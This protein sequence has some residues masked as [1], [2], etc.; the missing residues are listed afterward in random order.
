[1]LKLLSSEFGSDTNPV[2][3]FQQRIEPVAKTV[4]KEP[5][6]EPATSEPQQLPVQKE[7]VDATQVE[8]VSE[9]LDLGL[10]TKDD[11]RDS[12]EIS[13]YFNK[14]KAFIQDSNNPKQDEKYE[15]KLSS[16]N[17]ITSIQRPCKEGKRNY[18]HR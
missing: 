12:P 14:I 5:Q 4:T 1:M 7:E 16:V 6:D 10:I 18:G 13:D 3:R 11:I 2:N 8:G 9:L 15:T 17:L